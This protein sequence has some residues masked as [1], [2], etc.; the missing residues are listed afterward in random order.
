MLDGARENIMINSNFLKEFIVSLMLNNPKIYEIFD[1]DENELAKKLLTKTNGWKR[2]YKAKLSKARYD[3]YGYHKENGLTVFLF[4]HDL[5]EADFYKLY[6]PKYKPTGNCI[7]RSFTPKSDEFCDCFQVNI[8][9]TE[10]DKDIL[11][12][13]VSVD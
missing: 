2:Q 13:S 11:S 1:K 12:C 4:F 3:F 10:N 8:V 7:F 5:S 6:L 9:T